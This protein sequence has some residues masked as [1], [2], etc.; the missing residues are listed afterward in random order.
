MFHVFVTVCR[1]LSQTRLVVVTHIRVVPKTES[2]HTY[3]RTRARAH[4]H[5]HI[6]TIILIIIVIITNQRHGTLSPGCRSY[7][8]PRY[9][10]TQFSVD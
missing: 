1:I 6:H 3:T 8:G 5:T 2:F 10:S 4:I 7:R 9:I